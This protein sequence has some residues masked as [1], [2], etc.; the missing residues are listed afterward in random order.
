MVDI[1]IVDCFE[2]TIVPLLLSFSS[3]FIRVHSP[4]HLCLFLTRYRILFIY[5]QIQTLLD[6]FQ[7]YNQRHQDDI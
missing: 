5:N 4:L 6:K 7:R 1:L 2:S 3:H